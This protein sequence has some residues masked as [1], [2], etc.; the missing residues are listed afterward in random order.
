MNYTINN[1]EVI[2]MLSTSFVQIE[3]FIKQ[4]SLGE[5]LWLIERLN[6]R[7][8]ELFL[9]SQPKPNV[10]IS[11]SPDEILALVSQV[12]AG[13]STTDIKQVEEVALDRSNFF[14]GRP[15]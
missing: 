15:R 8:R 5:L 11:P 6:Q 1:Q 14:A 10:T 2:P 9:S 7:I 3:N 13:L 4:L 12:Y